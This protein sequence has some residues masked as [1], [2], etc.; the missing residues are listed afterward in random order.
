MAWEQ[1]VI[2]RWFRIAF[3]LECAYI[4]MMIWPP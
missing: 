3:A 2:P 1:A 4:A